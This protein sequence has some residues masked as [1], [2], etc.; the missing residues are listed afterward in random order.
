[1]DMEDKQQRK[2]ITEEKDREQIVLERERRA[3]V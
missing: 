2:L 1:M 3:S